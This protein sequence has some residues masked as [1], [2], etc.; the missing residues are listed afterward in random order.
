MGKIKKCINCQN[1]FDPGKHNHV[2]TCSKE[3]YK[4]YRET[5]EEDKIKSFQETFAKK[6][7]SRE[8]ECATC[9]NL[10][11]T[12]KHKKKLNCSPECLKIYQEN[13]KE[14]RIKKSKDAIKE[15][16]GVDHVSQLPGFTEKVKQTKLENF[17]DENYNNREQAKE[18]CIEKYGVE[19]PLQL[20]NFSNKIKETK[21]EKY[22]D[23]NFNNRD[24]ASKTILEKY[25]VE[26][27][28]QLEEFM[29]K[30]KETNFKKYGEEHAINN[31]EVHDKMLKTMQEKYGYNYFFESN[32]HKDAQREKS[33]KHI[34]HLLMKG[35]LNFDF[36]NYTNTFLSDGKYRT[37]VKYEVK[38]NKCKNVFST[39]FNRTVP[40]CRICNPIKYSKPEMDIKKILD[41]FDIIYIQNTKKI[42]PPLE[43][44]FFIPDFNVA[45]EVNGNYY[46]SE[47]S[48]ER[49]KDYHLQ[50]TK[51]CKEK[52]IKL[53]HIF[54]DEIRNK[55]EI[56]YSRLLN[57]LNKIDKKIFARKCE[58]REVTNK[59]KNNF[60]NENH[61]QG[62]SVDSYRIGL[63]NEDELVSIMTFS[64][65]RI[66]TG[67]KKSKEG[68][69]ELNRFCSLINTNVVGGFER[70]LSYFKKNNQY[71][72]IISYADCRWSGIN[73][74][75]TVY[76]KNGFNFLSQSKPSYFYLDT[77]DYLN[78]F[79][80]FT[81]NKQTL[82]KEF[83][84]DPSKT[85]W[86]LAQE[87][88]FDRIWD[89]GTMKFEITNEIK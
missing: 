2:L 52:G 57:L 37:F 46:H 35:N 63:Y 8:K 29:N 59:D 58:I 86:E 13:H 60:L 16:Y 80:R 22:G 7:G 77:K 41:E 34:E 65:K 21:K 67:F 89:C 39:I 47:I 40:I 71:S 12:G 18:T 5:I 78:R 84:G 15:K 73:F 28:L 64:K 54:D 17:G 24:K 62:A 3:C 45:I 61:I 1:D 76:H 72:S 26:H 51:L 27:H 42:I 68:E 43:L 81:Y 9:G 74:E 48:G 70:L 31:I 53:I 19:N 55:K 88:G 6:F 20:E 25:G 85:E 4:S 38:C 82:L 75:N 50:K 87:N 23:G 66:V 33:I 79:H 56:V 14:E 49:N 10:F 30:M 36:N 32:E 83:N 11:N 44:D 69:F